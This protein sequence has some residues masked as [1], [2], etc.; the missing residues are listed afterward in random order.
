[1]SKNIAHQHC[2]LRKQI[3]KGVLKN[4]FVSFSKYAKFSLPLRLKA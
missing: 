3:R 4:I 2:Y 1:M